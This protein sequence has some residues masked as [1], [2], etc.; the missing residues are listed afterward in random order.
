MKR[1]RS[2]IWRRLDVAG[3]EFAAAFSELS[4]HWLKGTA[5]FVYNGEFC[6]LSYRIE[7]GLDWRTVSA[8]VSGLVGE[9]KIEIDISVDKKNQWKLNESEIPE[10][11]DCTDIDLNFSPV[12][13]TLPIRRLNLAVGQKSA[14]RAA[15]L[16]FPSFKLE[17]LEQT[18]ERI[19]EKLYHYESGRFQAKIEVDDFG[20][21][22]NYANFWKIENDHSTL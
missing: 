14:V 6:C 19:G 9:R 8:N 2:I 1:E 5:I 11:A 20:F 7:C 16:R 13:N 12:T 18:Y 15:W 10:T 3:H 21:A 22:T 17:P 4:R